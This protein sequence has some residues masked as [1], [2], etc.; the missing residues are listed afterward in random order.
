MPR[1]VY[2]HIPFCTNKC[3]YCDFNSYVTKD[4][5]LIWNY[6]YALE[7]EMKQTVRR[8]PAQQVETI[9]VGG[10]TPTFL[11]HEQMRY[12]LQSVQRVFPDQAPSMEFSME[13]N[14]GTTDYEKLVIMRQG[15]INRLSY[16]AQ[17]FNDALLKEIG[18]MH[19]SGQVLQS[20]AAA[21]RAGFDNISID[22]IFG[23]PKQTLTTFHETLDI[24][25]SLDLQHF[26]AYSLQVE[27]NTLF[28]VLYEKNQLALP[29]EDDEVEMYEVVRHRMAEEGYTQY[30][31]SNFSKEGFQSRHNKTYWRNCE[32]YGIGAGAHGYVHGERHENAGP[33]D[34]YIQLVKE[35]G[36]PRI[37]QHFVAPSEAMEDFMI[38]GLR[39]LEGVSKNVFYERYGIE[40]A[41]QFGPVL[42]ELKN[43]GLL[44][45][46]GDRIRLTKRGIP[47]GNEVFARFLE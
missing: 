47:F 19:D 12:F 35:K 26:S 17:S 6:L 31:I 20:I 8:V 15:G 43:K 41:T 45:E 3:F 46:Q 4:S 21:K 33:V 13:A 2:I 23:L 28:H 11:D 10:G 30:E 24:A 14:P 32:Y 18:R 29:P 25:F 42:E 44:E 16:G 9:F 38:M 1:S 34:H 40:L 7:E 22:L 39:L 37:E 5:E 36:L 27:E